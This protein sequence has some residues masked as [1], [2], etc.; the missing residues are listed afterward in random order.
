[1]RRQ[2]T[3]DLVKTIGLNKIGVPEAVNAGWPV[4]NWGARNVTTAVE[5]MMT[6]IC[7]ELKARID[8]I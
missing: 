4:W 7:D 3:G 5:N 2:W 6:S 8:A 1:M